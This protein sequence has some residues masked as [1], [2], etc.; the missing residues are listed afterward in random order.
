MNAPEPTGGKNE[1][2]EYRRDEV[3][4]ET[5]FDIVLQHARTERDA[6]NI[7]DRALQTIVLPY[8]RSLS[9]GDRLLTLDKS[10]G[11]KTEARFRAALEIAAA[12]KTGLT[13]YASPDGI[14]W[15]INTLVWAAQHALQVPGDFVE[16][17]VFQGDM[18]L[19]VCETVDLQSSQK[20]FYLYDSFEGLSDKYSSPEDFPEAP[21]LYDFMNS[22]Y[23]IDG[24]YET[25][26]D[27]FAEK[28]FV[29]VIKGV[30][31][32]VLDKVVPDA[33][34]YL[35]LDLNA[36]IPERLALE[37]LFDRVSPSGIVIF[38][39][40]GWLLHRKQKEV[41]DEFVSKRGYRI[42]E[43]PTG[44]GLLIKR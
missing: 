23:K 21:Q 35:H 12:S 44:Q 31:P 39:D 15:R 33:I 14:I 16:C 20:T 2:S 25:V 7:F 27:R 13:Q 18:S 41:A 22:A 5:A 42:L 40:Y 43:M 34:A 26:R 29:R 32:D 1:H 10:V 6:A 11:F 30:I 9:W 4:L 37:R 19:A 24:L 36:P 38:D 8:H 17:G 28:P 3:S